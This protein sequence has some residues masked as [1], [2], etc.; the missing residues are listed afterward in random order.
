MT[1]NITLNGILKKLVTKELITIKA[2]QE[3][4]RNLTSS[5]FNLASF[6]VGGNHINSL[7]FAKECAHEFGLAYIDIENVEINEIPEVITSEIIEKYLVIPLGERDG[8]IYLGTSNPI[9]DQAL[10]DIS[11]KTPKNIVMV[12]VEHD[13]LITTISGVLNI[14]TNDFDDI[15]YDDL[16]DFDIEMPVEEEE[17]SL[18]DISSDD[19]PIVKYIN[20]LLLDAVRLK[21]SDIH[22]EPYEKRVRVR[23]RIDGVLTEQG[24]IPAKQANT[25]SARLKVMADLNI[26]ERRI[27][28]DGRVKIKISKTKSIDFRVS[29]LPTVYGEKV[30]MRIMDSETANWGAD[31]IEM[32]GYTK[33]QKDL[34]LGAL[35][36]PQGMILVTGPTGSGKTVSLYTGLNV[37]NTEDVNI[38]TAEDPVEMNVDGINQVNIHNKA[39]LTFA[40][41]LRSF[42]RQDPDIIMVGEIRDLETAEISIKAAQTGH[43]VMSTLHTNSASE[44]LARLGQMGVPLFNVAT[45]VHLIIAQRLARTLCQHCKEPIDTPKETFINEGISEEYLK[46][47]DIRV[48]KAVGCKQCTKGYKGRTGIYEVVGISRELSRMIME[49]KNSLELSD[50][51]RKEGYDTLRMS[52]MKKAIDGMTSLDEVYRVTTD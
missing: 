17:V 1:E 31:E 14:V 10:K 6:L 51:L 18:T 23:F 46:E 27:P 19:S 7:R 49:G 4:Q 43:L 24:T 20:K 37:L 25:V 13:K 42:L 35:S 48:Y 44:T 41:A 26:A 12:I 22:F 52:G 40:S 11:F 39:G 2:A 21:A 47:K 33:Q 45:S 28:Q 9:Q 16:E 50:Q 36:K 30:V 34:F 5:N 32:L 15:S 38:S 3:A 29:T 8:S